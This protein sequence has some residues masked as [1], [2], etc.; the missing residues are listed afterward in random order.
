[1]G[2]WHTLTL[3]HNTCITKIQGFF[4]LLRASTLFEHLVF[5]F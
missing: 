3:T 1:M 2:A 5:N 4:K